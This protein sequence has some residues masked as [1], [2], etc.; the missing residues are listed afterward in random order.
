MTTDELNK[1]F[2]RF[3]SE[4]NNKYIERVDPNALNQCFD[5]A[6]YWNEYLGFPKSIYSG[7]L[8]AYQIYT[9]WTHPQ[10]E[11]IPNTP[12]YVPKKGDIVVWGSSYNGGA[13]H[14]AV[15]TG[16]GNTDWFKAFSQN[17]PT[18]SNS[19]LVTFN[20]NHVLGAQRLKVT[21]TPM[22]PNV[23][24]KAS[25]Y[26]VEVK[27][28]TEFFGQNAN[29]DLVTEQK[30][31]EFIAWIKSNVQRAGKWDQLCVKAF[32][33]VDSSKVTV[34]QLYAKIQSQVVQ[35][36]TDQIKKEAY[37]LAITDA[38]QAVVKLKK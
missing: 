17:V 2:D 31:K 30:N 16:E 29:S 9:K 10:F 1:T 24:R 27:E 37:N 21:D 19:H 22:N 25:F 11:K 36:N 7:L 15:A 35:P 33:Q 32:G 6:I 4:N 12:E 3:L 5:L 13:G 28:V 34:D 26:D 18:G 8:N 20:Y 14:V 23:T 38:S